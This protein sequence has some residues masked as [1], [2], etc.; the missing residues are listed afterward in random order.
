[1]IAYEILKV[2]LCKGRNSGC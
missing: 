2:D 1:M